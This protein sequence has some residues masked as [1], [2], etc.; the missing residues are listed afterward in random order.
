MRVRYGA[1]PQRPLALQLLRAMWHPAHV[2]AHSHRAGMLAVGMAALVAGLAPAGVASAVRPE[3]RLLL[4]PL[5]GPA[6]TPVLVEGVGFRPWT[7]G[8]VLFGAGGIASFRATGRGTFRV[9]LVVP[10]GHSGLLK[11]TVR[12]TV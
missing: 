10:A 5:S 9:E 7:R 11:L 12:Q 8:T 3:P 1:R 4:A 2:R 6:G